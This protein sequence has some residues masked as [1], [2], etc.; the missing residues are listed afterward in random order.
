MNLKSC[1][2]CGIVIDMKK[3]DFIQ[4]DIP[5]NPFETELDKDGNFITE[6]LCINPNIIFVDDCPVDTWKCPVCKSYN[7]RK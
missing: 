6:D 3:V 2:N 4:T 5:C 1:D 7:G